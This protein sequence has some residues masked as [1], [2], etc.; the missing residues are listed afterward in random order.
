VTP[1][2]ATEVATPHAARERLMFT[3]AGHLLGGVSEPILLRAFEYWKNID[4]QIGKRIE[5][6]RDGRS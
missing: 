2:E 5:K 3:V 1:R 6:V 4:T